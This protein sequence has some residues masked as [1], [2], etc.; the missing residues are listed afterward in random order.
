MND[1]SFEAILDTASENIKP[2]AALPVGTYLCT[3]EDSP[4]PPTFN[5]V[6]QKQTDV[7]DFTLR[8][9][10]PQ[11]DVNTDALAEV[12]NG[13][14]LADKKIRHRLFI[15]PSSAWRLN[16]FLVDHLGIDNEGKSLRQLISESPGRQ[17]LVVI[18]HRSSTDGT[19]VFQEVKATAHVST[20]QV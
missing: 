4:N 8:P 6:G 18:G 15:T 5:K 16:Q 7:V 11:L 19:Q 20:A 13:G 10:Q 3:V 14:R 2:P 1:I 17:V 12:L 9:Q